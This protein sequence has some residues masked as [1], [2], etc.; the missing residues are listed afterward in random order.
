MWWRHHYL[1][2]SCACHRNPAAPR[3]RREGFLPPSRKAACQDRISRRADARLLDLCDERRD[4]GGCGRRRAKPPAKAWTNTGANIAP[5]FLCL[6]QESSRVASAARGIFPT[7]PDVNVAGTA[8][9]AVPTHGWWISVTNTEMRVGAA[10][11]VPNRRMRVEGVGL[12]PM[13][14]IRIGGDGLVEQRFSLRFPRAKLFSEKI[15]P[16]VG[17]VISRSSFRQG[18]N[19]ASSTGAG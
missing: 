19:L 17:T 7:K 18:G 3:P 1:P 11:L 9:P 8:F 2:H 10:G 5:S 15:G 16:P 4:E 14:H 13:G 12:E 6:S